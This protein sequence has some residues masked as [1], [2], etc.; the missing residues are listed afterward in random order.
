MASIHRRR[1][2]N[3]T[4]E[5][6]DIK[7]TEKDCIGLVIIKIFK[8][9]KEPL[10]KEVMRAIMTMVHKIGTINEDNCVSHQLRPTP[11]H[12]L[13]LTTDSLSVEFL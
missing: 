7:P 4:P 10:L 5:G 1:V 2:G 6:P 13:Y 3:E 11:H 9:Q 8:E 12:R